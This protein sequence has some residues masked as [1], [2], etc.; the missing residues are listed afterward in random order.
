MY[1]KHMW[2]PWIFFALVV[3]LS[4]CQTSGGGSTPGRSAGVESLSQSQA[5]QYQ[6]ALNKL[7]EK[8]PK[9]QKDSFKA[10][11]VSAET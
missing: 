10:W 8:E 1:N 9:P 11:C 2:K 3:W 7:E 6:R 5:E 4:G